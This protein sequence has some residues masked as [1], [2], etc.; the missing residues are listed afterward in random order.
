MNGGRARADESSQRCCCTFLLIGFIVPSPQKFHLE[1]CV[2]G[3]RLCE[4][5]GVPVILSGPRLFERGDWA[6]AF[7]ASER[8]FHST[9]WE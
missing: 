7:V 2:F 5:W 9:L 1:R 4:E 8:I 6:E 3:C